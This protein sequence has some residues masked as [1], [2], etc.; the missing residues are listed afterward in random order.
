M[1]VRAPLRH[2]KGS[3]HLHRRRLPALALPS[4][5]GTASSADAALACWQGRIE[6]VEGLAASCNAGAAAG[7][8]PAVAQ[9]A[10]GGEKLEGSLALAR[11][12]VEAQRAQAAQAAA[13]ALPA[14]ASDA[15][16][17]V[18]AA[19]QHLSA[20]F[21][22]LPFAGALA[23]A[24][25]AS[26]AWAEAHPTPA[27]ALVVYSL[28]PPFPVSG[29]L[30]L[31]ALRPLQQLLRRRWREGDLLTTST[32]GKGNFGQVFLA[33]RAATP[34]SS[35]GRGSVPQFVLK[36]TRRDAFSNTAPGA[37]R[38]DFLRRGTIAV[39]AAETSVAERYLNER[40][41]LCAQ[42]SVAPYRGALDTDDGTGQVLVW[43]YEGDTTLEAAL[44]A[45][46]PLATIEAWLQ[47]SGTDDFG[48]SVR[49]D[50]DIGERRQRAVVRTVMRQLLSALA[51]L[52]A[53]GIV[54][55]DIK[56]ANLLLGGN[57]RLRVLD[58][59][60]ATDLRAQI[61]FNPTQGFFDPTFSPPELLCV[62]KKCPRA[63]VPAVATLASPV[64]YGAFLPGCFDTF[65][66]GL[67]LLQLAV[68]QL[69][70]TQALARW[71]QR[72]LD[73]YGGDLRE[74]RRAGLMDGMDTSML[75]HAGGA[76]WAL[77]EAL[78]APRGPLWRGRATASEALRSRFICL[79]L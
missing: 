11:G 7:A 50:A 28:L 61:N 43:A 60:A 32:L 70:S 68:P 73:R 46:A 13:D 36:R 51:N 17:G 44:L 54:H 72:A 69:R 59:G 2:A 20:E 38:G 42:R 79:P 33:E 58:F 63:T 26:V 64:L 74:C 29:L 55:R 14:A 8:A 18:Y 12:L 1:R 19:L 25:A 57:S 21:A 27:A 24:F 15:A 78:V 71:R 77:A 56:P 76:G 31:Y 10:A 48:A 40:V 66:A 3:C 34:G 65:S 41:A 23:E 35:R 52:D 5:L 45:R 37:V 67:L 9:D 75:D 4:V 6:G 22:G 30:Y 53:A 49:L 16:G 62:P 39:G 47:R